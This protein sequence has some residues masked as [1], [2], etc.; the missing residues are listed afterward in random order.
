MHIEAPARSETLKA[1]VYGVTGQIDGLAERLAE[2][3]KSVS[4]APIYKQMERLEEIK[5]DYDDELAN[6]KSTGKTSFDR[7]VNFDVFD[8]FASHY[9]KFFTA[10]IPPNDLKQMLKRFI[11]R[12]DAGVDKV[13]VHWLVDGEHFDR[14][15]AL[16]RAG[17]RPSG[18]VLD[19]KRNVSSQSLTF[20]AQVEQVDEHPTLSSNPFI[21]EMEEFPESLALNSTELRALYRRSPNYY[22]VANLVGASEAFVRQTIQGKKYKHARSQTKNKDLI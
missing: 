6:L 9:R 11:H 12:V 20:G 8:D 14:E 22:D 2:L 7:V 18:G 1:K 13:Q 4:A 5:R 21:Y 19:F 17:S 10:V 16:L 3:P 15:L